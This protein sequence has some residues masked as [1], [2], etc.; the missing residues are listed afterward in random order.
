MPSSV[1]KRY[2]LPSGTHGSSR[3]CC[4]SLSASRVCSFS[5][6][7]SASRAASQSSRVP[8]FWFVIRLVSFVLSG[9]GGNGDTKRHDG[10]RDRHID[11][12]MLGQK[13]LGKDE[14]GGEGHP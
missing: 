6:T 4:A 13:L 14:N 1:S 5:R 12:R 9:V 8:I 2:S 7:S 11:G 3:R 10:Q